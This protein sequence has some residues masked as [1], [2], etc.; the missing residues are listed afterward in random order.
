MDLYTWKG[1][2]TNKKQDIRQQER[3]ERE[4][5]IENV[6]NVYKSQKIEIGWESEKITF[7]IIWKFLIIIFAKTKKAFFLFFFRLRRLV[8]DQSSL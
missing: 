7:F 2:N 8:F 5:Q 6:Q 1:K 3:K 4:K